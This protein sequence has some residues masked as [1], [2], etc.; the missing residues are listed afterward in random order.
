MH[1]THFDN[2][3]CPV[4]RGLERV[5]EWWSILILRDALHG[6]R[7]FDQFQRSLS[8]APNMLTRR[9]RALVAGGLLE[10]RAYSEKPLRYEYLLTD[11]GRDFQLVLMAMHAW[12]N[13]H[14]APE[15]E[16]VQLV[17]AA[18]GTPVDLALVDRR[19]GREIG[20]PGFAFVPGPAADDL[21]RRRMAYAASHSP[22]F[23][24]GPPA[25]GASPRT[26]ATAPSGA[27][28]RTGA[29]DG[30]PVAAKRRSGKVK[31]A[32]AARKRS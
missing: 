2:L 27:A 6:L 14:F 17:D 7:R 4:A 20:G 3:P 5:G 31:P 8:I 1:R 28:G 15:G 11:S 10:R 12:G 30:T 21:V 18:S 24:A 9:L 26:P 19:S 16:S 23:G 25:S 32:P 13:R 22:V 29:R